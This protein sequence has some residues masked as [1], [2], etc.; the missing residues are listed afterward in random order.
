M[1]KRQR[2][3]EEARWCGIEEGDG[4]GQRVGSNA[5]EPEL[6][7][8][9]EKVGAQRLGGGQHRA[10]HVPVFPRPGARSER[11]GTQASGPAAPPSE[12]P[13][14]LETRG[15]VGVEGC[16]RPRVPRVPKGA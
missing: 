16:R 12:D 9:R 3:S 7:L 5:E 11:R 14:P 10:D 13:R 8:D 1:G 6:E 15:R 4:R 2:K